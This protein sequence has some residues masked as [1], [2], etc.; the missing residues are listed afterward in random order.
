MRRVPRQTLPILLLPLALWAILGPAG[1]ATAPPP[2]AEKAAV[3][4]GGT[5]APGE[6]EISLA[7]RPGQSWKSRFVSTSDLKRTLTG[8]DGK[9]AVKTRSV[10]LEVVATQTVRSVTGDAARIEVNEISVR[11]LQDGRFIDA[12]FRAFDPPNPFSFT[13]NAALGTADFDELDL[14]YAKWI[15]GV[16]AG[17]AGDIMGRTFNVRSYI[18]QMKLLYSR[19]FLRFAGR[20]IGGREGERKDRDF[21]VPFLGPGV[22]VGPVPVQASSWLEGTGGAEGSRTATVAGKYEG[23]SALNEAELAG[24][25]AEFGG[26]KADAA[27]SKVEVRG[28]YRSTVEAGS[29]RELSSESRFTYVAT[30]GADGG[31][32]RE[33]IAGKSLLTPAQ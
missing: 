1:C 8:R 22:E 2:A 29:G 32:F 33:E 6:V 17:P 26:P 3:P 19:P 23:T 11:I 16:R 21:I 20:K 25:L 24:R 12:P 28:E 15:G 27:S 30:A 9:E 10:G 5:P 14:E 4:P 18:T 7:L 13:L 31:T